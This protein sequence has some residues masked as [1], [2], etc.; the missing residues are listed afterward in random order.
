MLVIYNA[1]FN[2]IGNRLDLVCYMP[3]YSTA[4]LLRNGRIFFVS[5]KVLQPAKNRSFHSLYLRNNCTRVQQE[6]ELN[7]GRNLFGKSIVKPKVV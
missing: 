5:G 1:L 2:V 6:G 3:F 4:T 7:A